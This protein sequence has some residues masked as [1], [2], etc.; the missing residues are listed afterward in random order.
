MNRKPWLILSFLIL[1]LAITGCAK[2]KAPVTTAEAAP[3]RTAP[4]PPPP[5]PAP[6]PAPAAAPD[7]WSGDLA[8]V[9][10]YARE[11]GLLGDVYFDYDR[12]ELRGDARERLEKNARFMQEHPHFEFTVEGHCD[13]R[14][15]TEYNIALG[16]R[17]ASAA[18]SYL[19]SSGVSPDRMKTLSY[20]KER[21]L[22][23][24]SEENCWWQNRRAHFVITGRRSARAS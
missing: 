20:G 3:A 12:S 16:E 2:K 24:Q 14:G 8:S 22:C 4:A 6:A 13:E 21:P 11:Q 15:T 19:Y 10:R 7:P 1:V 18:T 5:A 23:T 17:R 9:N